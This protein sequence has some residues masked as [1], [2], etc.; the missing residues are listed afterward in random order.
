MLAASPIVHPTDP[1]PSPA[2]A[3]PPSP[4]PVRPPA[5]NPYAVAVAWWAAD[6]RVRVRRRRSAASDYKRIAL[7]P[8]AWGARLDAAGATYRQL[9]WL[10]GTTGHAY[11]AAREARYLALV[12]LLEGP[13]PSGGVAPAFAQIVE[14]MPR[15]RRP[16]RG[17]DGPDRG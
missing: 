4:S 15:V 7:L 17:S 14:R 16:R 11:A 8:R 13:E 12:D 10:A 6:P 3:P 9:R 5:T 2:P 1:S